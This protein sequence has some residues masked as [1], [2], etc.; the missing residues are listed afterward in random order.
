MTTSS[1]TKTIMIDA[2]PETVWAFLTDKD[3][4]GEWY[5]PAAA[6]LST[7]YDYAL[8]EK[9]KD[10]SSDPTIWGQVIEM[11][12]P[13]RLVTT[14]CIAPFGDRE[15]TLTWTLDPVAGGTRVHLVHEGIAEAAG[16][17]PL[18]LLMA[19][20]AGWD[21]HFA[22]LRAAGKAARAAA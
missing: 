2:A 17:A 22:S 21:E 11:D 8:R 19:L 12:P 13:R 10:P 18:P 9:G 4:L 14:F 15:T 5:H 3:R 6:D 20:D 7:D 16:D 1:L